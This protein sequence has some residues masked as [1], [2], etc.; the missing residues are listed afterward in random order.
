MSTCDRGSAIYVGCSAPKATA[1]TWSMQRVGAVT[2]AAAASPGSSSAL[3][4]GRMRTSSSSAMVAA[5]SSGGAGGSGK[6]GTPP[7]SP[8]HMKKR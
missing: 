6:L 3:A 7:A 4:A 8:K 5:G 2:A 1:S